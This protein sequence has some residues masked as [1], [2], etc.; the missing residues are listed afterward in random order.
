MHHQAQPTWRSITPVGSCASTQNLLFIIPVGQGWVH[1]RGRYKPIAARRSNRGG[2][3]GCGGDASVPTH[4]P[5]TG[6]SLMSW[7]AYKEP[8]GL[9]RQDGPHSQRTLA[10][11]SE[12][13]ARWMSTF[14]EADTD[15]HACLGV[16]EPRA[17]PAWS[18]RTPD[19]A[20]GAT[21]IPHPS[22]A[23]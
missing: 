10:L 13:S 23:C 1:A 4:K 20:S 12:F 5:T 2:G 17:V 6:P 19:M 8:S 11:L 7:A 21:L 18:E 15:R 9:V 14:Q 3:S 22:N 16:S